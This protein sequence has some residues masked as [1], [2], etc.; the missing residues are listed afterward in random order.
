MK[1]TTPAAESNVSQALLVTS[2]TDY[3]HRRYDL[4]LAKYQLLFKHYSATGNLI[5]TAVALNG[6]GEAYR[7][8]GDKQQAGGRFEAAVVPASEDCRRPLRCFSYITLNLGK[9]L[10]MEGQNA[11]PRP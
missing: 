7:E 6:M 1:L 2:A 3:S 8:Q 9:L 10:R 11:G 4:A 5:L